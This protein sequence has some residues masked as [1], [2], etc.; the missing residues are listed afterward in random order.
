MVFYVISEY[1]IYESGTVE[2]YSTGCGHS[3]KWTHTVHCDDEFFSHLCVFGIN[4]SI[5]KSQQK[6]STFCLVS[7]NSF[8]TSVER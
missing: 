6:K 1:V 8:D 3:W 7:E 2:C 4:R 5:L